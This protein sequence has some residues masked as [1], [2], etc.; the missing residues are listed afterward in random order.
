MKKIDQEFL[1]C[2]KDER[3]RKLEKILDM[4]DEDGAPRNP[5]ILKVWRY[6]FAEIVK[7][8]G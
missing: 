5:Q 4:K 1:T 7:I 6:P 2:R 3:S 8:Q